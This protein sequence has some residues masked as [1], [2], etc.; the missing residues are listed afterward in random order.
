MWRYRI[1]FWEEAIEKK[2][3]CNIIFP[4]SFDASDELLQKAKISGIKI[5]FI[6]SYTESNIPGY[7]C[8]YR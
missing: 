1:N 3:G 2:S 5:T 4:S 6:D 7:D 8:C